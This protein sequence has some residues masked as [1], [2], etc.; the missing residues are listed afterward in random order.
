MSKQ[1]SIK[2]IEEKLN[3]TL[4]GDLLKNTLDFVAFLKDCGMTYDNDN[5]FFYM[6]AYTYILIF[7][8]DANNPEGILCICDCP[9]REHESFPIDESV[10]EYVWANVKKCKNCGCDDKMRGATK[11]IFGKEFDNLC[12]SEVTFINPDT[13][14]F[15]KI[16]TLMELWKYIIADSK[17]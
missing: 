17:K 1:D 3:E 10:K 16:K 8:K 6:G 4:S 11:A 14:S 13:E 2:T 7:F 9:I 15:E 12:S 5:R